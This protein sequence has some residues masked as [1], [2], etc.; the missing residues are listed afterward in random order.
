MLLSHTDGF[1]DCLKYK[2]WLEKEKKKK[3]KGW[4]WGWV[5]RVLAWQ[6]QDLDFNP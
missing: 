4:N 2:S 5:D 6:K 1:S 3:Y